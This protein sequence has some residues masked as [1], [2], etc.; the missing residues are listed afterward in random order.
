MIRLRIPAPGWRKDCLFLDGDTLAGGRAAD[1]AAAE[2]TAKRLRAMFKKKRSGKA[3][4]PI[5][6]ADGRPGF[7]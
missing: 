1:P 4:G 6:N 2:E 3:V 7:D 5:K